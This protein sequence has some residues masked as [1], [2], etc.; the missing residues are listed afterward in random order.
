MEMK[1]EN[2]IKN[3]HRERNEQQVY[4]AYTAPDLSF[5]YCTLITCVYLDVAI[6]NIFMINRV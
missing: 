3:I 4:Y 1:K 2:T 6:N 5:E